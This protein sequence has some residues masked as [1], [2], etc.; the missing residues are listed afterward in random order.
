M[1]TC[2]KFYYSGIY[3]VH[4]YMAELSFKFEQ[5]HYYIH[6]VK[7][8]VEEFRAVNTLTTY[9]EIIHVYSTGTCIILYIQCRKK[10][11]ATQTN[12]THK[13]MNIHVHVHVN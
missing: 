12:N 11:K 8:C 13:A 2:N 5:N 9:L 4:V 6:H 3:S 10:R 7:V 1:M